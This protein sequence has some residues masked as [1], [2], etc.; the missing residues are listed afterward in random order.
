MAA[1]GETYALCRVFQRNNLLSVEKHCEENHVI[2]TFKDRGVLV[3][4]LANNK[5]VHSLA[6]QQKQEF[7]CPVVHDPRTRK[8][9]GV[10]NDTKICQWS[11]DSVDLSDCQSFEVETAIASIKVSCGEVDH[12]PLVVFVDGTVSFLNKC[13]QKSRNSK[14]KAKPKNIVKRVVHSAVLYKEESVFVGVFKNKDSKNVLSVTRLDEVVETHEAEI[15]PPSLNA[16]LLCC[17]VS[18]NAMALSY[19]SDGCLCSCDI[20]S[21]LVPDKALK[22]PIQLNNKLLWTSKLPDSSISKSTVSMVPIGSSHICHC[23]SQKAKDDTLQVCLSV[24]DTRFGTLQASKSLQG[25][26]SSQATTGANTSPRAVGPILAT[27]GYVCVGLSSCVAAC[28][29]RVEQSSLATALGKLSSYSTTGIPQPLLC[30]PQLPK[31]TEIQDLSKW[32]KQVTSQQTTEE[33]SLEKLTDP[34]KTSTAT[35]FTSEL[36]RYLDSKCSAH[37][38]DEKVKHSP[39]KRVKKQSFKA[40][41]KLSTKRALLSQHFVLSVLSRCLTEEGFWPTDAL[42]CLLQTCCV[43]AS[44]SPELLERLMEKKDINLI[45]QCFKYIKGI[46][47]P[48]VVSSL[49]FVL[50]VYRWQN[51]QSYVQPYT[52][53]LEWGFNYCLNY[54]WIIIVNEFTDGKICKATS[55]HIPC[56]LVPISGADPG[57]PFKCRGYGVFKTYGNLRIQDKLLCI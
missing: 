13:P 48:T 36:R 44:S 53:H 7:T 5:L 40:K 46:P 21:L 20:T 22:Q 35:E 14:R 16:E 54:P 25:I 39:I 2:L 49:Q 3:Y 50:R 6:A 11:E 29:C 47:E 30:I 31:P 45:M 18:N 34:S 27:S 4:N 38:Q 33:S 52:L 10:I 32:R 23:G 26:I 42:S 15:V 9:I 41:E 17:C 19:W 24:I 51:M 8:Y 55:S 57:K 12:E 56:T 43:P 28:P 37:E 1:I